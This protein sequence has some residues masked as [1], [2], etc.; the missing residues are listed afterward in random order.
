[1]TRNSNTI[2][3]FQME[4]QTTMLTQ[5]SEQLRLLHEEKQITQQL[6]EKFQNNMAELESN[7]SGEV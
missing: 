1:M 4:D 7:V 6:V 3:Y 2:F 5:Q